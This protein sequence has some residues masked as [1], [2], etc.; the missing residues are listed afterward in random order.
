MLS[1][2]RPIGRIPFL[3]GVG[4]ANSALVLA[5]LLAFAFLPVGAGHM[6]VLVIVGALMWWWF[7]LHARRFAGTGRGA[8]WPAIMAIVAYGTFALSYGVIAALWSVPEVQQAAFQTGGS[9]FTKHVETIPLV[10]DLGRWLASWVGAAG[11]IILAG[12]LATA[13]GV[14]SLVAGVFSVVT[15]LL[16]AARMNPGQKL[17]AGV[18]SRR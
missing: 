15:L 1:L 11:A 7:S 16:P 12:L 8:S 14:V 3:I 6:A 10:L 13:M 4:L 9:D 5:V 18:L 17:V 2:S